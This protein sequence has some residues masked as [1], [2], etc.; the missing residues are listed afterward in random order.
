MP[1]LSA[2]NVSDATRLD[3]FRKALKA[4]QQL[5]QAQGEVKAANGVYRAV[6]KDAKKAGV[7]PDELTFALAA[8]HI[9]SD[10]LLLQERN[11]IR[12]LAISGVMPTIQDDLFETMK[13]EVSAEDQEAVTAELAYDDGVKSGANGKTR[14]FN[15]HFQGSDKYDAWDRGWIA[16]QKTIADGMPSAKKAR[17]PR[18]GKLTAETPTATH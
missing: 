11:R 12:M 2:S 13:I 4:K 18:K 3:Y 7:T 5:E 6:L 9:D 17:T 10:E 15:P 14:S 16:G 1:S 8:R